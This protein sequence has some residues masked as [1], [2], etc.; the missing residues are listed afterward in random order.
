MSYYLYWGPNL[1][2]FTC[3]AN[4]LLLS[5][6]P[7]LWVEFISGLLHV[8]TI[9]NFGLENSLKSYP[10]HLSRLLGLHPDTSSIFQLAG[11][12]MTLYITK[13]PLRTSYCRW[14]P[15]IK[16]NPGYF[17]IVVSIGAVTPLEDAV[18][19]CGYFSVR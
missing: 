7:T 2:P 9:D 16:N 6:T 19:F 3:Q 12:K 8:D 10:G 5:H 15:L 1:G 18:E 17:K 14:V 4:V 11:T 13:C